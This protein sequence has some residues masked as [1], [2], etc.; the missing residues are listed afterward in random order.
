MDTLSQAVERLTAAGYT[1]DFRAEEGGLRA[2]GSDC[3]HDPG[4]LEIDEV[5][6]FEGE[7]NPEDQSTLFAL[8][9]PEHD[10][11]GTY[12]V[13]YGPAMPPLDVKVVQRLVDRRAGR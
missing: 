10:R 4:D 2:V 3:L 11:R 13:A 5:L 12:V 7:S 6:R 1:D 9:C 8:R